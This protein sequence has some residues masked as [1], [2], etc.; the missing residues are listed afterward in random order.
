MINLWKFS[1]CI[2][3][4]I[5]CFKTKL[6]RLLI[7]QFL[8]FSNWKEWPNLTI[9]M[10]L[11]LLFLQDNDKLCD[12][13]FLLYI[14]F[15]YEAE[16]QTK[17]FISVLL[18]YNFKYL[19]QLFY[20]NIRDCIYIGLFRALTSLYHT[21]NHSCLHSH[22]WKRNYKLYVVTAAVGQTNGSVCSLFLAQ[23][24]VL[25]WKSFCSHLPNNDLGLNKY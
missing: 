6:C 22:T 20:N 11:T 2:I 23:I 9:F 25:S 16:T 19:L 14:S 8:Y 21:T 3:W 10:L 17:C 18:I 7:S 13:R 15:Y 1:I 12:P 24:R 5:L 4:N